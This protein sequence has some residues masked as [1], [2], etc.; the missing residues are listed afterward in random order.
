MASDHEP[1]HPLVGILESIMENQS[2]CLREEFTAI[3]EDEIRGFKLMRTL[4][5]NPL[6]DCKI[7]SW[8]HLTWYP[9]HIVGKNSTLKE[10]ITCKIA[11][12]KVGHLKH[13]WLFIMKS[14]GNA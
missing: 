5:S 4:W 7:R 3:E 10:Y 1:C 2:R 9:I 11:K 14:R 8:W 12:S 13:W 6:T